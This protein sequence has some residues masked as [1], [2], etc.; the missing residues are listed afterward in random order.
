[1][2]RMLT[3]VAALRSAAEILTEYPDTPVDRRDQFLEII[4]IESRMPTDVC[5]ALAAY[6]DRARDSNRSLTP[7]V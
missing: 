6:F 4:N 5:E 3:R 2:H 7:L 1:M